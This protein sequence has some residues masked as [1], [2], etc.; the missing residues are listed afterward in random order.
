M[1]RR[2]RLTD[3]IADIFLETF[4]NLKP[5]NVALTSEEI[6][7]AFYEII[8]NNCTKHQGTALGNTLELIGLIRGL[9]ANLIPACLQP[10]Q[11]DSL[12]EKTDEILEAREI[13]DECRLNFSQLE[14]LEEYVEIELRKREKEIKKCVDGELWLASNKLF[15]AIG[16]HEGKLVVDPPIKKPLHY[17]N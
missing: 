10:A 15:I 17:K 12:Q 3:V 5:K 2:E 8:F 1:E 13:L 6:S 9:V 4:C 11:I 16:L 7:K 14:N